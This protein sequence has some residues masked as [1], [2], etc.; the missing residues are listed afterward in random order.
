VRESD[1]NT[2]VADIVTNDGALVDRFA[3]DRRT[4]WMRRVQ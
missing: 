2:I 3:V 4:G 1:P